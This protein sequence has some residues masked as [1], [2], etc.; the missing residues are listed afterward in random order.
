MLIMDRS[1]RDQAIN[2]LASQGL[3]PAAI[4]QRLGVSRATIWRVKGAFSS[5]PLQRAHLLAERVCLKVAESGPCQVRFY[6][7][8]LLTYPYPA[9]RGYGTRGVLVGI[10]T[11]NARLEWLL[12]D[13]MQVLI[14]PEG[15]E[16]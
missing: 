6:Q 11:V 16:S 13:V 7:G 14:D 10:Y 4:S 3:S 12:D 8:M 9:R 15:R 1:E 2:L 5:D